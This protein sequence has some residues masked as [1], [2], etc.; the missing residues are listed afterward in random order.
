MR[1]W[2]DSVGLHIRHTEE[3]QWR[4]AGSVGES[5]SAAWRKKADRVIRHRERH[6]GWLA[7][8]GMR[9]WILI[10]GVVCFVVNL[11]DG[12]ILISH[13]SSVA[14]CALLAACLAADLWMTLQPRI[15]CWTV[16]LVLLAGALSPV[17]FPASYLLSCLAA[18]GFLGYLNTV[19][20]MVA[21]VLGF[22]YAVLL[23]ML[24]HPG[25]QQGQGTLGTFAL[26]CVIAALAGISF[27]LTR[28]M[29]T[30]RIRRAT[31]DRNA[32]TA[33]RLHDYTT[34]DLC[35]IIMMTDRL[36]HGEVGLDQA[37][38]EIRNLATTALDHTRA[39]IRTLESTIPDEAAA[40]TPRDFLHQLGSIAAE[41][42]RSL[43]LMGFQGS[44][45]VP[46]HLAWEPDPERGDMICG[47]LRELAGNIVKYASPSG[48]YTISVMQ[49]GEAITVSALNT[50]SRSGAVGLSSGLRRYQELVE[51]NGGTWEQS[52]DGTTWSLHLEL[53]GSAVASQ[54]E[55]IA[56]PLER[57]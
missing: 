53:P 33:R 19:M 42:Q 56:Y 41:Q 55:D 29:D 20:G 57:R 31:A 26:L 51:R 23:F 27:R 5:K 4:M 43:S 13:R 40:C 24:R 28:Q 30:E 15:G 52:D 48:G 37:G 11:A 25:Y 44:I 39:V 14:A 18:A 47:L 17:P 3:A 12:I 49:T 34:N 8:H 35:S 2:G 16:F 10:L 46:T 7:R 22:L 1:P 54:T 21:C 45:L 32:Q 38:G 36:E 9:P 50:H 6:D